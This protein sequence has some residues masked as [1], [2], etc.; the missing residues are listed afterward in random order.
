[1]ENV[2]VGKLLDAKAASGR[3]YLDLATLFSERVSINSIE[4]DNVT[5]S[6][7]RRC[8]AF[9]RGAAIEGKSGV[10]AIASIKPRGV[11]LDVKPD[12]EPFDAN[13]SFAKTA[14]CSGRT[15]SSTTGWNLTL[16]PAEKGMD[17][18]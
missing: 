13:L 1:M 17:F 12:L 11:K 4:L 10:G 18:D 2:A 14:R 6:A 8:G 15:S 16:K 9:P 5:L 3:I 7:T